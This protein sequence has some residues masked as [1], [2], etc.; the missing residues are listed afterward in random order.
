MEIFPT[1]SSNRV[2][3]RGF[4]GF[5]KTRQKMDPANCFCS[6]VRC[7]VSQR[8][9][10]SC[11]IFLHWLF[12]SSVFSSSSYSDASSLCALNEMSLSALGVARDSFPRRLSGRG[13]RMRLPVRHNRDSLT[14]M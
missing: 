2:L 10:L 14:E 11:G 7:L 3:R 6:D 9:P 8:A 13:V 4:V 1:S 5:Y 12:C